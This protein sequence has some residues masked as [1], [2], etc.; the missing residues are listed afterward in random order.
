MKVCVTLY[1]PVHVALDTRTGK[2]LSVEV[3]DEGFEIGAGVNADDEIEVQR[4][5][6]FEPAPEAIRE[7]AIAIAI[8]ADWP[9]WQIGVGS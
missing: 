5:D 8:A 9:A 7:R 3:D 4:L 1:A 2:V 6:N